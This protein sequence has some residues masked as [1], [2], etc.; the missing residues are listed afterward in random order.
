MRRIDFNL[1]AQKLLVADQIRR[2]KPQD[3]VTYEVNK[4][5]IYFMIVL[6]LGGLWFLPWRLLIN[7]LKNKKNGSLSPFFSDFTI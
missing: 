4:E 3:L 6:I 7:D 5:I 2:K 1:S